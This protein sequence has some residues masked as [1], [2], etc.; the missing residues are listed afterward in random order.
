M[1]RHERTEGT[2][3]QRRCVASGDIRSD[4]Q[5]I[6]FVADDTGALFPDVAARAPGRGVWVSATREAVQ[7]A[8]RKGGF[9]RGLKRPV[10]AP[11]GLDVLVESLLEKRVL[12]FI[13]LARRSGQ[14]V[15]GF[16]QV[17]ASLRKAAPA[18]RIEA[19]DS[20]DDGRRKLDGLA[21]GWGAIPV[22]GCL[23]AADM[24]MALGRDHV[25]HALLPPGRLAD[26]FGVEVRRL[27]GFRPLTPPAWGA[28]GP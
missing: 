25:V 20:A 13:G 18:W 15:S 2:Q 16:D 24:G 8:A 28:A 4:D 14:V 1:D 17:A 5:L 23:S 27:A 7:L 22:A 11:D 6:R 9:A 26:A 21:R 10:K 12:E 3:R 19:S